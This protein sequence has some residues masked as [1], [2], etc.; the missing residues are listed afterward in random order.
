[1]INILGNSYSDWNDSGIN[2]IENFV[3]VTSCGFQKFITK[4]LTISREKGR[5]DYQIIYIVEGKG[6]FHF[7]GQQQ[8]ISQGSIITYLPWQPQLYSYNCIDGT[9]LYWIHFSGYAVKEF[10][11]KL[12]LYDHQ[13]LQV[14]Y[15]KE[16][17]ELFKKI[18][19]EIQVK[20]SQFTHYASAY[21]IELLSCLARKRSNIEPESGMSITDDIRKA[22]LMMHQNY[23]Q[24]FYVNELAKACNLS[25]YR[26]IHKFKGS[27]GLTPLQYM[28]KIRMD[29]AKDLLSNSSLSVSEVSRI[30]GYPDPLYF[31]K[32][33]KSSTSLSPSGFK[34][35]PDISK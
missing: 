8:E 28:T 24:P 20:R 25:L 34:A 5:I 7:G 3:S 18:T 9:E 15:V 17:I 29:T 4:D 30:V 33:F 32:V 1:M 6:T 23:S 31:S 14:G 13:V 27:T 26:F 16:C 2:D 12:N 22:I 21:F 10:L 11:E 35:H 19:Y